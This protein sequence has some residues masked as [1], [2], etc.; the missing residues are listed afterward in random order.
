MT[1]RCTYE[2]ELLVPEEAE[3]FQISTC[4]LQSPYTAEPPEQDLA[5]ETNRS[6][7]LNISALSTALAIEKAEGRSVC[8]IYQ[9]APAMK[10][11]LFLRVASESE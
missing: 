8:G 7:L 11:A 1:F 3:L 6:V 2:M 10:K 9:G 4:Y 5:C